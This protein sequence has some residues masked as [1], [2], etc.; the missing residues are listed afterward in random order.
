MASTNLSA[1]INR[2]LSTLTQSHYGW[3]DSADLWSVI[4]PEYFEPVSAALRTE[5][6]IAGLG[7]IHIIDGMGFGGALDLNRLAQWLIYRSHGVGADEAIKDLKD[8]VTANEPEMLMVWALH[9]IP[10]EAAVQLQPDLSLVPLAQLPPCQQKQQ[11][12]GLIPAVSLQMQ[13]FRPRPTAALVLKHKLHSAISPSNRP[14][15]QAADDRTA[16]DV[17]LAEAHLC[18]T[19][20]CKGVIDLIGMWSQPA[21][22][23][24]PAIFPT[25]AASAVGPVFNIRPVKKFDGAKV[26]HVIKLFY[27]FHGDRESLRVA[28]ERLNSAMAQARIVDRAIDLGIALEALLMHESGAGQRSDNQEIRFK[29]GLRGAWLGAGTGTAEERRERVSTLRRLYDFRSAAVHSGRITRGDPIDIHNRLESGADLCAD[30][31]TRIL[32]VGRWPDWDALV[33]GG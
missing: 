19:V 24:V 13:P 27:E 15:K 33:V 16:R 31:I 20:A 2:V 30:L 32:E 22:V 17:R 6:I 26:A 14:S 7:G 1:I 4:D 9:G 18:M 5:P 8:F 11:A 25:G 29:I 21:D 3:W 23:R 12:L 10:L 28:M